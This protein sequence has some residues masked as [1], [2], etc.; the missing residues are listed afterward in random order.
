MSSRCAGLKGRYP[1][2]LVRVASN[3]GVALAPRP[4]WSSL[5]CCCSTSRSATSD[6]NLREE[7]RFEI[8]RLPR[9]VQDH[10]GC[11]SRHDQS[12]GHGDLRPHRGD[13]QGADRADRCARNVAL[14][15]G[16]RAVSVGGF[17]RPGPIS[18]QAHGR[19]A[20]CASTAFSA[21]AAVLEGG[22]PRAGGVAL[23]AAP[24]RRIGLATQKPNGGALAVEA[25][26]AGRS[27]L[28]EYWDYQA[29]PL[30]RGPSRCVFLRGP[31][32]R[33]FRKSAAAFWL[34]IDP[35]AMVRVE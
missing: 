34:E 16:R 15:A 24:R 5:R 26:I 21:A 9:R 23:F 22:G 13:E 18:S 6:A 14:W 2:E 20:R 27:Y 31:P 29:R 4:S 7:M 3:S 33:F 8:R 30:G 25:E 10:D 28:G 32:I 12:E 35:A 17:H 19:A 11:T 1:A